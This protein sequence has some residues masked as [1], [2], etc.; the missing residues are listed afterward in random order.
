GPGPHSKF[1]NIRH[2]KPQFCT[3]VERTILR[4]CYPHKWGV[5]AT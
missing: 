5:Q 1:Q 2:A 4:A 3:Q